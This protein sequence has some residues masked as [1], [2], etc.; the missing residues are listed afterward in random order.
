M[1]GPH[2]DRDTYR[3]LR[4]GA[5]EPARARALAEHLERSCDACEAFLAALPPD[6][7]DGAVDAALG[8]L[9]PAPAEEAG[10]DLEF[11]RVRRALGGRWRPGPARLVAI[12]AAVALVAGVGVQVARLRAVHDRAWSGEKGAPFGVPA[13]LRFAV[14]EGA[15]EAPR[16]ERGRSGAVLPQAARLAFRAEVGGPTFL[17]LVHAGGG[18]LEVVWRG[19][20]ERAGALDL[21]EGGRAAAF[22]LQGLAGA[23]RFSLVASARPLAD[24]ELAAAARAA[25]EPGPA[26]AAVP[27]EP[28]SVDAVEVTVR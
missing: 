9:A 4:A 8:A 20:A 16:L 28:L 18:E 19:R 11:A 2:L 10:G 22:P 12:A 27:G 13:R 7:L 15:G 21:A 5:L 1:D 6:A 25:A 24:A 14:V 3:R 23:Q 17:A 26:M